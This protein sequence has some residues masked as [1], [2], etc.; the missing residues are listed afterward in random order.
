MRVPSVLTA[1]PL[2]ALV[3]LMTGSQAASAIEMPPLTFTESGLGLAPCAEG[4]CLDLLWV[5]S[6]W[7][8]DRSGEITLSPPT[9]DPMEWML[10]SGSIRSYG[11]TSALAAF[12]P[13]DL[14][15]HQFA[16]SVYQRDELFGQNGSSLT[17]IERTVFPLLRGGREFLLR[18]RSDAHCDV[19]SDR[20]RSV[21]A[22][23]A[24]APVPVHSGLE[25]RSDQRGA[26][27]QLVYGLP[28][29]VQPGARA[30]HQPARDL[31]PARPRRLA[32]GERLA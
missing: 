1:L 18:R 21:A 32:Q 6:G 10:L 30:Q 23:A 25:R 28:S 2:L 12:Q 8:S 14:N 31:W 9:P 26:P 15:P 4:L 3:P 24:D 5:W 22:G 11:S 19:H 7:T 27:R 17:K 13:G 20:G 29:R 16:G